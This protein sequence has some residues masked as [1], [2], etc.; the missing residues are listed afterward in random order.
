MIESYR[1]I[2]RACVCMYMMASL[3][4]AR[5]QSSL[6]RG[7]GDSDAL[8]SQTIGNVDHPKTAFPEPVDDPYFKRLVEQGSM[9][10][11]EHHRK[12][13]ARKERITSQFESKVRFQ[14]QPGEFAAIVISYRFAFLHIWKCGGTTMASLTDGRQFSLTE[15]WIQKRQWVAFVRDPIDRFLSA[16]AECGYRQYEGEL[17][18]GGFEAHSTL[19]WLDDT[20]D[21]RVRAFLHEVQDFTFPD[22]WMSCHT[23]AHPQT[24]FMIDENGHIDHHITLVGDLREMQYVLDIAGF[25][26]YTETIKGRDSSANA[27]KTEYFPARRDLLHNQTLLELCEFLALDYFLFDFEPPE[28]CVGPGGPLARFA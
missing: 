12:F 19:N 7:G 20:Y 28:V 10:S 25:H 27:V 4:L 1:Y 6:L 2:T 23:H 21:F 13:L 24:N 14:S 11:A 15:P 8:T 9:R 22:V 17:S 18:F 16:W 5:A 3:L 26:N